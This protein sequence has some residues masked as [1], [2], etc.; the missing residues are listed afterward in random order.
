[1]DDGSCNDF[2]GINIQE[3]TSGGIFQNYTESGNP[4]CT[5]SSN[6]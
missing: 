6:Y 4:D 5:L 2:S 3:N 1:M